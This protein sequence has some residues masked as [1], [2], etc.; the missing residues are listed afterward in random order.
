MGFLKRV[1]QLDYF[2]LINDI[3]YNWLIIW[4]ESYAV[5]AI[6]L[7]PCTAIIY[8]YKKMLKDGIFNDIPRIFKDTIQ[9]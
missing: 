5:S 2:I 1:L 7:Q 4:I 6:L 9:N 8:M 3:I